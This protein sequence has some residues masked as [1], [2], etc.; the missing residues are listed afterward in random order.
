MVETA[1]IVPDTHIPFHDRR[2]FA[3]MIK[4][5]KKR[6]IKEVVILGDFL[7]FYSVSRHDKD[8]RVKESLKQ[9]IDQGNK[10]LDVLDDEFKKARKVYIEGNH[11]LRLTNY[12]ASKA[13][14]IFDLTETQS[15][16]R[17]GRRGW[18]W[19]SWGPYQSHAILGSSFRA[20]HRPLATN[21][22][23]GVLKG[24]T[25]LVYGDI[26]KIEMAH[27]NNLSGDTFLN[28]SCGWLGDKRNE[29]VFG[30]IQGSHQWQ[31]GFAFLYHDTQ[32]RESYVEI[33]RISDDYRCV[34]NGELQK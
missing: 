8:P 33:V 28:F 32:T 4:C 22:K 18:K 23:Q 6:K 29:K 2:A 17:L 20:R 14:E 21:P 11:E 26:H 13:P 9:E 1:L 25:N 31:L 7:D 12:L 16:L 3:L 15:L 10:A 27:A 19:V 34:I 5:A 30:Y 24:M